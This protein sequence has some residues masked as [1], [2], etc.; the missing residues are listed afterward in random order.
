MN[1]L[2]VLLI[3]ILVGCKKSGTSSIHLISVDN[4]SSSSTVDSVTWRGIRILG[5]I[6][7]S[8]GLSVSGNFSAGELLIFVSGSKGEDLIDISEDGNSNVKLR[9]NIPTISSG[10]KSYSIGISGRHNVIVYFFK[11]Q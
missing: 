8:N 1:K 4:H 11:Q 2:F 7:P 5:E 6:V 9:T 10:N 3:L